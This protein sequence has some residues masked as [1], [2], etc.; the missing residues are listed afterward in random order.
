MNYSNRLSGALENFDK[1]CIRTHTRARV[2]ARTYIHTHTPIFCEVCQ[3][4]LKINLNS[5]IQ[6]QLL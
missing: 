5:V 4:K 1:N 3:R 6:A 2:H